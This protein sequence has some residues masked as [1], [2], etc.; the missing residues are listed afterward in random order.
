MCTCTGKR[1]QYR[2]IFTPQRMSDIFSL[3]FVKENLNVAYEFIKGKF[4]HPDDQY[5]DIGEGKLVQIDDHT[6][7]VY[8]D[9]EEI[10]H[11]VDVTCPHL[12]CVCHFNAMDKTWDCPCHGSRFSYTGELIKG[13]A[14]YRLHRYGEGFNEIDPHIID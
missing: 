11:I 8:R 13:P 2:V 7:G 6:Y 4:K 1:S 5:P 12:G 14:T 10:L 9:E 3:P